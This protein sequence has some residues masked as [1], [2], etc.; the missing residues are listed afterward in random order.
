MLIKIKSLITIIKL[1]YNILNSI[2]YRKDKKLSNHS[3][4]LLVLMMIIIIL[5][6]P[7]QYIII[8]IASSQID[9]STS[10]KN[11]TNTT[12]PGSIVK[13]KVDLKVEGTIV[14]D[15]N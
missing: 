15:K 13:P 10:T 2:S 1:T 7:V 4:S 9:N 11:I 3:I 6:L 8:Q 5:G 14:D 12:Q